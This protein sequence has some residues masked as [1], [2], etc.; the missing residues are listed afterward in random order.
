MVIPVHKHMH[1]RTRTSHWNVP[2]A[3]TI[4][5]GL[6]E[7]VNTVLKQLHPFSQLEEGG[8]QRLHVIQRYSKLRPTVEAPQDLHGLE[9]S[10]SHGE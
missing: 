10:I 1:T 3:V 4:D 5:N 2:M 7:Q 6:T 8:E 9:E